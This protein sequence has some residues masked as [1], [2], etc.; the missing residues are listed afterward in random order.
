MQIH[1]FKQFILL[2]S[3]HIITVNMSPPMVVFI[4]VIMNMLQNLQFQENI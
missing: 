3:T 4:I 2:Y 1:E